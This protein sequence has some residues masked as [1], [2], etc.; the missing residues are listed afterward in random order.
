MLAATIT[1]DGVHFE[2]L[3]HD[4]NYVIYADGTEVMTS[5][6]HGSEEAMA[7]LACPRPRADACILIGGLGMGYT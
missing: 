2:L 7:S 5:Y 4:D 6:S 3:R 1:P